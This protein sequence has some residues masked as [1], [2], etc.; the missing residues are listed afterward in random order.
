MKQYHVIVS[1][2]VQGVGFRYFVQLKAMDYGLTGWVKNNQNGS[3]ELVAIGPKEKLDV[4][5]EEI[6]KGNRFASVHEVNL[7]EE[8]PSEQLRSFQ[9]RY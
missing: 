3:V 2:K 6:K 1:G 7:I 5:M 9:I 4:F 8:Q